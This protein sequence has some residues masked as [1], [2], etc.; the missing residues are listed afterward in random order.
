MSVTADKTRSA[1]CALGQIHTT[2]SLDTRPLH[3]AV[4]NADIESR[5]T[6]ADKIQSTADTEVPVS[7]SPD[8]PHMTNLISQLNESFIIKDL[9]V[10]DAKMLQIPKGY[11]ME[12]ETTPSEFYKNR[13]EVVAH[14]KRK[15]Q[16]GVLSRRK[17]REERHGFRPQEVNWTGAVSLQNCKASN[18]TNEI[19]SLL[20]RSR[21]DD[22]PDAIYDQFIPALR[23]A[24]MFLT[25]P[26]CMQFWTTLATG[27][28]RD[29]PEMTFK[30]GRRCQRI[31]KHVQ[32]TRENTADIIG[33]LEEL[34]NANIIHFVFKHRL[35]QNDAWGCAAPICDHHGLKKTPLTRSFIQL[36]SDVYVAA[37]KL[38][39]LKYPEIS[40][41]LRFNFF[42]ATLIMHEL[43]GLPL[44]SHVILY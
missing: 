29:D 28:R 6:Q 25:Q 14:V 35:L 42:F 7:F 31:D 26:V 36:H 9:A 30:Y 18:L 13:Q 8:D 33:H 11:L 16:E 22:T 43:V 38:S 24:T 12:C 23:L 44:G 20:G 39:Q 15:R 21:F 32:M 2:Q 1:G 40:Q 10:K 37:K 5:L 34:G 27:Q 17:G 3:I 4:M 19:H 41:Q